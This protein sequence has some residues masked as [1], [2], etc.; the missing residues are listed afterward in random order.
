MQ[1]NVSVCNSSRSLCLI[2]SIGECCH[3]RVNP[4][5][6]SS[7]CTLKYTQHSVTRLL[8]WTTL[9][10]N[11]SASTPMCLDV[12]S[13]HSDTL[14][15]KA[16]KFHWDF[17]VTTW[18]YFFF[19]I[20]GRILL[21]FTVKKKKCCANWEKWDQSTVTLNSSWKY[22]ELTAV[23]RHRLFFF[24][25]FFFW[26]RYGRWNGSRVEPLFENQSCK[27]MW[28][29]RG[30]GEQKEEVCEGGSCPQASGTK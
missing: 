8:K 5:K 25:L 6:C 1:C 18:R 30:K 21:C 14:W 2:R 29:G 22:D 26:L 3:P 11:K 20:S 13:T 12:V 10:V 27:K 7:S 24:V 15:C 17:A 9:S 28:V 16:D 4:R 19:F 23:W